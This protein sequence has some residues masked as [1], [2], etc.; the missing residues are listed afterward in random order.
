MGGLMVNSE[1]VC[2]NVIRIGSLEKLGKEEETQLVLKRTE[3]RLK[4]LRTETMGLKYIGL[5]IKAICVNGLERYHPGTVLLYSFDVKL[6]L[7]RTNEIDGA[8]RI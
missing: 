3:E 8:N 5:S 7:R 6:I 1:R 4:N 2:G